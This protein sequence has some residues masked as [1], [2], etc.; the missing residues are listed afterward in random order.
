MVQGA[1]ALGSPAN[2]NFI[3]NA[4]FVVTPD[5]VVVIDALGSPRWRASCGRHRRVTPKP[6]RTWW[7]RTTTPTTST[8]CRSS[9]TWASPSPPTVQGQAYLHSDTPQ[10]RLQASREELAPWIDEQ[11][12]LVPA[13]R[14]VSR[15]HALHAGRR[16]VPAATM[17]ARPTRPRTWWWCC[18][19]RAC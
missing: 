18:R 7:S 13:D 15:H 1:S 16:G 10:L 11:T 4:A 19:S 6:I 12:R 5:G 14:W 3:S 9:R 8:A 2:R 17:P